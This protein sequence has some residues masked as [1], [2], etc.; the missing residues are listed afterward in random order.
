MNKY[1]T[2]VGPNQ[3]CTLYGA[4][5]GQA[6]VR[7]SNYVDVGYGL[8]VSDL[9]RRNFIVL[10]GFCLLFQLTQVLLM[11]F[12]PQ[13]GGGSSVTIFAPE[14]HDTKKRNVVLQERKEE[15]ATRKQKGLSEK[16]DEDLDQRYVSLVRSLVLERSL[17]R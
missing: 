9:W 1:P 6:T 11:E 14:D 12:F 10:V 8:N 13:F 16:V 4:I 7:G 5:P 15:K 17:P 2:D 3:I